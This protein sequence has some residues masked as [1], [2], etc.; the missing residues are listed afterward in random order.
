MRDGGVAVDTRRGGGGRSSRRVPTTTPSGTARRARASS[1]GSR[2]RPASPACACWAPDCPARR[3]CS[4]PGSAGPSSRA[5]TSSTCRSARRRGTGRCPSTRSAT[6]GTSRLA[7]RHR[8]EQHGEAQ[9]SLAV[10]PGDERGLQHVGGPVPRPLQPG[11]ANRNPGI[12]DRRR[13]VVVAGVAMTS[14]GNSYARPPP[15]RYRRSGQVETPR[16]PAVPAEDRALSATAANVDEAPKAAGR[17]TRTIAASR[18]TS[19]G[20]RATSALRMI[21]SE[22][23]AKRL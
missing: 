11:P 1:I 21:G 10:C 23:S 8:G 9:L 2:P 5:S 7:A 13:V 6:A 12:G 20:G 22:S 3:T 16:A 14:T 19:A 17:L 4:W 15:R 18:L